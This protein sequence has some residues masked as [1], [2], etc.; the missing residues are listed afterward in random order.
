MKS[1]ISTTYFC[2]DHVT[3]LL[4]TCFCLDHVVVL[5]KH[6]FAFKHVLSF[7]HFSRN[8]APGL[9]TLNINANPIIT[10]P[11]DGFKGL[12]KLTTLQAADMDKLETIQVGMKH[13]VSTWLLIT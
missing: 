7:Q 12:E 5:F 3:I 10:F 13:V 2:S 1:G 4:T 8:H 11:S 9:E 6:V